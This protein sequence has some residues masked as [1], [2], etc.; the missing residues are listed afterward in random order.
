M[1]GAAAVMIL[2]IHHGISCQKL[3]FLFSGPFHTPPLAQNNHR[4]PTS[5]DQQWPN[6][7]NAKCH[8]RHDYDVMSGVPLAFEACR[9]SYYSL[10]LK[11]L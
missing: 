9:V 5:T 7:P 6:Q 10:H 4:H 8:L 2:E 3:K 1:A 11:R